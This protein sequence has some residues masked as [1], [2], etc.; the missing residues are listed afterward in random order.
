MLYIYPDN[1]H[2]ILDYIHY[3]HLC[4]RAGTKIIPKWR[5]RSVYEY[6]QAGALCTN[7]CLIVLRACVCERAGN[8]DILST[9][10]G[11]G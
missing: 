8:D 11:L 5:W 7:A 2:T 9:L 3:L 1:Y 10:G 4:L 6:I